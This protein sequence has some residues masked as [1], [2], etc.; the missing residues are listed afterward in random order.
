MNQEMIAEI[1]SYT[2]MAKGI[3]WD[4]CHKIYILLD[5]EQVRLMRE[6]DYEA[7]LTSEQLSASE[8]TGMVLT[9]YDESCGLKFV[10]AVRTDENDPNAG[11]T[12]VIP[13]GYSDFEC[14]ICGDDT[15]EEYYNELC[16]DCYRDEIDQEENYE[17]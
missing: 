6:Y 4:T 14:S 15:V 9:W 13:Q 17:Q 7:I 8:M 3:A 2:S 5:D 1:D 16:Y 10:H 11:F 12:N